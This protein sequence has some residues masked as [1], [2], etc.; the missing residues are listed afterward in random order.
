[1]RKKFGRACFGKVHARDVLLLMDN[2]YRATGSQVA[3][4]RDLYRADKSTKLCVNVVQSMQVNIKTGAQLD[5][6]WVCSN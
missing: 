5:L 1:M 4:W 6:F 3:K 2:P